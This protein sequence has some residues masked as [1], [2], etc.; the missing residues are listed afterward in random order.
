M[1]EIGIGHNLPPDQTVTALDTMRDISAW[2]AENPVIQNEESARDAKVFLDRGKLCLK[3]MDDERTKKVGPF[4][5]EVRKINDYYRGPRDTLSSVVNVLGIRLTEFITAERERREKIARE[6][7]LAAQDAERRAREAERIEQDAIASADSG[8]LGVNVAAHVLAADSAFKDFE[9]A[10]RKAAV[11][12]REAHV[13]ISG[14]FGRAISLRQKETIIVVNAIEAL[15]C[16]G[17]TEY[18]HEAI[19]KS[20]RA[21]RKLHGKLPNGVTAEIT[22]E[23]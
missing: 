14:G 8:E 3:D 12:E 9:S 1:N 2:M 4:N 13:K 20:A 17:A 6:A 11:A 16:I 10:E 23:I 7:I 19:I 5:E 21:Y 22:E 18:I 15:K